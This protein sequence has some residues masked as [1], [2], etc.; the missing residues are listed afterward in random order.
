MPHI[1]HITPAL[2]FPFCQ[3]VQ[4]PYFVI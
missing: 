3:L 4:S 1:R 2:R